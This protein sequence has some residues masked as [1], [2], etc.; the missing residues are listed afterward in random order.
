MRVARR[1]DRA[2]E[3]SQRFFNNVTKDTWIIFYSSFD[4]FKE[5]WC[6][7]LIKA[8][9]MPPQITPELTY[10]DLNTKIKIKEY[11]LI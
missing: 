7:K 5:E 4:H 3:Q 8:N 1:Q 11:S 6:Y 9:V 10:T 2:F